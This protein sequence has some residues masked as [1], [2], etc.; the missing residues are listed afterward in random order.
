MPGANPGGVLVGLTQTVDP[1]ALTK[2][3]GEL[4]PSTQGR[5]RRITDEELRA[6]L[7]AGQSSTQIAAQYGVSRQAIHKRCQ[8]LRVT[9]TAAVTA[10][11]ESARYVRRQLDAMEELTRS[12]SRVNRLQD[13]CDAWLQDPDRPGCYTL[14]PRASEVTVVYQVRTE[15]G[16]QTRRKRL[17]ELLTLVGEIEGETPV[18]GISQWETK[19]ADPRELILRTVGECRQVVSLAADLA[20]MLADARVME[21]FRTAV[22][23]EI[24]RES[25]DVARR[26]A[27]A[28]QR[29]L[30]V[31]GAFRGPDSIPGEWRDRDT[32]AAAAGTANDGV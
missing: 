15:S 4:T 27:D 24:A 20:R 5:V 7:D 23:T 8:Q 31:C 14:D 21:Q 12:L 18:E 29:S 13:A 17:A 26:I 30:V 19:H 16:T 1:E 10:P 3:T 6:A 22:L 9:T 11:V 25:P 32:V 2:L 28:V